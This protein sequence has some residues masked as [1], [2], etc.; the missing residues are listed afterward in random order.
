MLRKT[1]VR[2]L[3]LG[4][5]FAMPALADDDDVIARF[6]GG[7][8]VDAVSAGSGAANAD[9]TLPNVTRNVIRGVAPAGQIW[10]IDKLVAKVKSDGHITVSGKGLILGGGN[11]AGRAPALSVIATFICDV[12]VTTPVTP[13][14]LSNSAAPG[15]PLSL[16]GN[17]K[18]DDM[19]KPA[20]AF[21]CP[22][23]SLLI[24]NAAGGGGSWFAV[25][26]LRLNSDNDD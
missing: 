26:N 11:N 3:L 8:G 15:V 18:I 4:T 24:R 2:L 1:L 25:G 6:K 14:V 7:I 13:F 23:P 16:E 20:P 9:G 5:V 17:F 21:N 22:N 10:V 12:P 19:L